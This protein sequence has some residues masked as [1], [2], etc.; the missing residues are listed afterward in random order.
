LPAG[1]ASVNPHQ[2]ATWWATCQQAIFLDTQDS[3]HGYK[4]A[5]PVAIELSCKNDRFVDVASKKQ[6][7][8]AAACPFI[9]SP[10]TCI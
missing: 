1:S 6:T 10:D 8:F 7:M 4:K 5:N 3:L 9:L 2:A